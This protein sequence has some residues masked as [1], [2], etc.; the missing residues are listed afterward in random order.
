MTDYFEEG[1]K[2]KKQV[3]NLENERK[4]LLREE[5]ELKRKE[6]SH[7]LI[8]RG[9]ILEKHLKKPLILTDEDISTLLDLAFLLDPVD[10]QLDRLITDRETMIVNQEPETR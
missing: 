2:L 6:R 3:R 5:K 7:R 9:A 1:E 10:K 4:V 8:V